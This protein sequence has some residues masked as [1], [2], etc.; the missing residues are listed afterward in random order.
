MAASTQ[1][2]G[3]LIRHARAGEHQR[4]RQVRLAALATNPEAFAGTYEHA[5]THP[6]EWWER[7]AEQ[8]D[9]GATQRTFIVE[10]DDGR[11]LGL[12]LVR[13]D[14][15]KPA[16]PSS[17]RCGSHPRRAVEEQLD[18]CAKPAPSGRPRQDATN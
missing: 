11:W 7:W 15:E 14:D 2:D 16:P 10:T 17:T 6:D 12:A 3:L 8:S 13:L 4:L 9:L 1:L 18:S 5:L